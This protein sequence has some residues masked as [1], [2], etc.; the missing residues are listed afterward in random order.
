MAVLIAGADFATP[1]AA[2]APGAGAKA[3]A[4][5]GAVPEAGAAANAG[6]PITEAEAGAGALAGAVRAA[7]AGA[8]QAGAIEGA[9]T[10][11]NCCID[12]AGDD[13]PVERSRERSSCW[14]G[15]SP[16]P[17]LGQ[18]NP[19]IRLLNFWCY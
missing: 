6:A 11:G 9:P 7:G 16:D 5:A 18:Y 2:A 13:A 17:N 14:I 19:N 3:M 10:P 1:V 8:P 12:P 4:G 15:G